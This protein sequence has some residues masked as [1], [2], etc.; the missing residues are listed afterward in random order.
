MHVRMPYTDATI[1]EAQR[2]CNVIPIV[3]RVAKQNTTLGSY[4]IREVFFVLFEINFVNGLRVIM[5]NIN[6]ILLIEN[7][8]FFTQ[9]DVM[10]MNLYSI[11]MDEKIWTDPHKFNP[12]RF[13]D[14]NQNLINTTSVIPFGMGKYCVHFF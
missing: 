4:S 7:I 12:S 3:H 8:D 1:L 13:L 6:I 9:G 5:I 10:V 11:H 14:E 2:M